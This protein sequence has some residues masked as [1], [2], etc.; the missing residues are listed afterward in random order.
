MLAAF[1]AGLGG[2]GFVFLKRFGSRPYEPLLKFMGLM[3]YDHHQSSRRCPRGVLSMTL[4]V[5]PVFD[6]LVV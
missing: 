6:P 4:M 3:I 2:E 5:Q 1:R